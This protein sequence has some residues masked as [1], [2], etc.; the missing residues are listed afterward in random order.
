MQR[1]DEVGGE[2][3]VVDGEIRKMGE[4]IGM[5]GVG[6]IVCGLEVRSVLV[7]MGL[8]VEKV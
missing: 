4:E 5:V 7:F 8:L 6:W 3:G 1:R 2:I